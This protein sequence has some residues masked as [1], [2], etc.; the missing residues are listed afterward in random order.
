MMN[1]FGSLAVAGM[2]VAG[3]AGMAGAETYYYY[4]GSASE[5]VS[6]VVG[7]SWQDTDGAPVSDIISKQ[8][9]SGKAD[10]Y[11]FQPGVYDGSQSAN[12][13]GWLVQGGNAGIHIL[14]DGPLTVQGWGTASG[15][16][17]DRAVVSSDGE[18]VFGDNVSILNNY[19]SGDATGGGGAI[20]SKGNIVFGDYATLSGNQTAKPISGPF[21]GG[22][23]VFLNGS[24]EVQ[25]GKS[26]TIEGNEAF[27]YGGGIYSKGDVSIGENAVI[28]NNAVH[29]GYGGALS[30]AGKLTMKGAS[31]VES[32]HAEMGGG[33]VYSTGVLNVE[34]S[35]FKKNT[36]Y[37]EEDMS[38]S[39]YGGAIF[40]HGGSAY[41]GLGTWLEDNQAGL[42]AQQK[43]WGGAICSLG[44]LSVRGATLKNN[45]SANYG[46]GIHSQ[47]SLEM[48]E[49]LMEGNYAGKYGGALSSAES[50][51]SVADSTFKNNTAVTSGGAIY[52]V[53]STLTFDKTVMESN[54]AANGGA[55]YNKSSVL[56]LTDSEIRGNSATSLGGAI[57]ANDAQISLDGTLIEGN[58]GPNGG[59]LFSAATSFSIENSLFKG[60]VATA[61]GGAVYAQRGE[62]KLN[63]VIME[64]NQSA[65]SGGAFYNYLS[66]VSFLDSTF[67][68]NRAANSGG[69]V[70]TSSGPVDLSGS[71][72]EEN[73]AKNG[74]VAYSSSSLFS[75]SGSTFK[76]N[77][78]TNFGG[79]LCAKADS[80][81]T[82][83]DSFAEGNQAAYGGVFYASSS[84]LS[85]K[86]STIQGNMAD[87]YGGAV[88][89]Q[90]TPGVEL[91]G[92]T[93]EGNE[94]GELG[95]AV[96]G[97]SSSFTVTNPVFRNNMAPQA[98]GALFVQDGSV[99]F[100]VAET[101][102]APA[103]SG[104]TA[105]EGGFLYLLRASA[106]FDIDA[107]QELQIGDPQYAGSDTKMDSLAIMNDSSLLKTGE[108]RLQINSSLEDCQGTVDVEAGTMRVARDW[109]IKNVLSI[110]GGS[111]EL[112]SFSFAAE[113][114]DAGIV[115]GKL[116]LAGGTLVT[117]TGQVFLNALNIAGDN[118]DIGGVK[119]APSNWDFQSGLVSFDDAKYNL[120]YAKNAAEALGATQTGNS[121]S[122]LEKE[123]LFTG[124]LVQPQIGNPDSTETLRRALLDDTRDSITLG[125]DIVLDSRLQVNTPVSRSV[126][127]DGGGH[128][129]SGAHPGF[130]FKEMDSGTVSIR[131]ITFDG[132]K[133]SSSDRYEGPV[134]FG[135][136]IFFDMGY[137]SENWD[138]AAT[139]IIGDGVQFKNIDSGNGAGGAVRTAHGTVTIGNNVQFINCSRGA[140]GGLYTE[141]FT[142]IGDNVVFEGNTG[143]RGGA[144]TAAD[145]YE[146]Y[147]SDSDYAAG[148][149]KAKYVH[150][151]KNA[152]FINNRVERF[153]SG[154]GGAI[155]VQSGDL[156]ISDDAKFSGN[157]SDGYGGAI[158]VWGGEPLLPGKIT[159][160]SVSFIQ[161][162]AEKQGGALYNMGSAVFSGTENVFTKNTAPLGGAIFNEGSITFSGNKNIFIENISEK[163]RGGALCNLSKVD[164]SND[165]AFSKNSAII[166]G[167][168]YNEGSITFSGDQNVFSGNIASFGGA[169]ATT[170]NIILNGAA[171]FT[172]NSADDGGAVYNV[173]T[174]RLNPN[175]GQDILFRGNTDSTGANAVY[176]AK[177]SSLTVSGA[178]RVV[179]DD[180]LAFEDA[181]P[182]LTKS[183]DGSLLLNASMDGM[184]G[185][186]GIE[187]GVTRVANTWHIGNTVTVT[188][189]T[190][191][192][193]TFSF[194]AKDETKGI[195][196][197]KLI[198]AGGTLVTNTGQVFLNALNI[199]GDNTDIGGVKLAPS[200]WDF[201]SGLVSFDDAKYNLEYAK[202][203]AEALGAT[204]ADTPRS[205]LEKE[206]TFTGTLVD[207]A[208]PPEPGPD[209]DPDPDPVPTPD[210]TPDPDPVPTPD[211]TP[212]PVPK[213]VPPVNEPTDVTTPSSNVSV[214]DLNKNQITNVVFGN[215]TITTGTEQGTGRN[216]VV[217][218]GTVDHE[219]FRDA[220]A[221]PGSIGSKN[222]DLGANGASV[223]VTG[224]HYLT[225]VGGSS[226]TPLVQAGKSKSDPVNVYVGGTVN[227]KSSSGMLNLGTSAMESGG[228]LTGNV[229]I[230]ESS[231]V[232]VRAGEHTIT[233]ETNAE[234]GTADVAGL[235]N[236]GGTINVAESARLQSTIRQTAGETNVSGTLTSA[237][238]ELAG[239]TLNVSGK[240]H[241]E[242][243][244]QS[245]GK[246]H[247]SGS[248]ES[249]SVAAS[250]GDIHVVG[251]LVTESLTGASGVRVFV[252]DEKASGKVVSRRTQLCGGSLFLDP[253]WKGEDTLDGASH[254]A[255][256]FADDLL[257]GSLAVGQNALL[258]LGDASTDWTRNAFIGSGLAWG[259]HDVTAA[260]AIRSPQTLEAAR[261]ALVVDGTLTSVP[262]PTPNTATFADN[263]LLIVDGSGLNGKAALTS[264]G[265]MLRVA[266][267]AKLLM[268]NITQGEFAITSGFAA[269]D[270]K[271]W[272]GSNLSTPDL[273]MKLALA[274]A[275]DGSVR[276]KAEAQHASDVLPGLSLGNTMDAVWGK[277]LNNVDSA[278]RGIR[279]LSR[280]VNGNY[281]DRADAVWTIDG[282]AQ[283]AV[284]GGA[285]G[286]AVAAAQSS[287]EAVQ[288]EL[289]LARGVARKGGAVREDGLNLWI[290]ALYGSE[291]AH[292][293]GA[294]T[295]DGG[296]NADFGGVVFGGDYTFG[297]FR[298]GVSLN[299]G[300]GTSRSRGDFNRTK[301]DF[302]F[303]GVSLYGAWTRDNLNVMADLGYSANKNDVKQH[304]PASL[305]LG[306]LE[307]DVDTGV[308][309][310]GLRGECLLRTDW[311]DVLPHIGVRYLG[312][313]TDAFTSRI[314]DH[315]V[316]RIGKETQHIWTFPVGVGF[317]R[318]FE[319]ASGWKVKPRADVSVVPATGD[320]KAKTRASVRGVGA[321]D[322][323]T[324]RI[325]DAT[326]VDGTLGLEVAKDN[327][328]FGLNYGVQ[329]SEHRTGQ[330]VN[331]S[332]TYKF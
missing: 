311:A 219:S 71:L 142:T 284:A 301:N 79:V 200:N 162:T 61:S 176:M 84:G 129:L 323:V 303:W 108:G 164:F 151:G 23:A 67:K 302:D 1:V 260:L 213:P 198:L 29:L 134:A 2:L 255:F 154:Y 237:S 214:A 161:N 224:G 45:R 304:L 174:M 320:L 63:R 34:G 102:A 187:G 228:K 127:I 6:D 309:T 120:E 300:S 305:Q 138:S 122:A 271:G 52:T 257:D 189:G 158:F 76:K 289:S 97:L 99:V 216:L 191:E 147:A 148:V 296:Y 225:L 36:A 245:D 202:N 252:G 48:G 221:L 51:V 58:K 7:G 150:I 204:Q 267:N 137:D 328:S 295:L 220:E 232:N 100:H 83:A 294:G 131:N 117:N 166:G 269:S 112:P 327:L 98:G 50:I 3:S 22:G 307:A 258:V 188:G 17:P 66:S 332:F 179:F 278:N 57:Y 39:E 165:S 259:Q 104:N 199:A 235:N 9:G 160:R 211:P 14:S 43:G 263:S 64:D 183:G 244:D 88:Y 28:R 275:E 208:T 186:V 287:S 241:V 110:T 46:G 279:F 262:T 13:Q 115:G 178:G 250:G 42:E 105:D 329:A 203:A 143:L 184:L 82:F 276:V 156:G 240:A 81:V 123:V 293:F 316:F 68:N 35:T 272:N 288:D 266:E 299:A 181:T 130:W 197:G 274:T 194:S 280:S 139:L 41:I 89:V 25:L 155:E 185:T 32:N 180:P 87:K 234:T 101:A 265:G 132:L 222:V 145:D 31:R 195:V 26:A 273:L 249:S 291:R 312:V 190:L 106:T 175:V 292:G 253:A 215:V 310:A 168:I 163:G 55:V 231:V 318:D 91:S 268:D 62:L 247:V 315:D 94:A 325:M 73:G 53:D 264:E 146:G 65:N 27:R 15:N 209:P 313:T 308:L 85:V 270:V 70:Y 116:I 246:T 56:S 205:A 24:G 92:T 12:S 135:S 16:P 49:T 141:S 113:D 38:K 169:I 212:D 182:R 286:M 233:G 331:L 74:G 95:G 201:Q 78:A 20:C 72:M 126:N 30:V 242:K 196:G 283:I 227:G 314:D 171:V 173:G 321:S 21:Y 111:L 317:S 19:A 136:A 77:T 80:S 217:G 243:L 152:Q 18:I 226:D 298:A 125:G 223:M 230:A 192:L 140:G 153:G 322:T 33:A 285:Q 118:T 306:Q 159:L 90:D 75:I 297:P 207:G 10:E 254:G 60:N 324:S 277:G 109:N 96:C 248:L 238:V 124:T 172:G 128:T 133:T 11:H 47:V 107:G 59:G 149:R 193:P 281:L 93:M 177:G 54:E 229:Q 210:P 144:L 206:V 44:A 330:G 103:I 121:D 4:T 239:G 261:G 40:N 167:A 218:A 251:S 256:T 5:A 119:L 8:A 170:G 157:S 114:Q 290:N 326:T 236:H 319:T 282:A 69:V 37:Y 86:D